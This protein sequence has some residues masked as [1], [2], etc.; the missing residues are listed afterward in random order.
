MPGRTPPYRHSRVQPLGA[1]EDRPYHLEIILIGLR[2]FEL[3]D[4]ALDTPS[5]LLDLLFGGVEGAADPGNDRVFPIEL[6]RHLFDD[7]LQ[8]TQLAPAQPDAL[9]KLCEQRRSEVITP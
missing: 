4:I 7:S 5:H 6:P 9:A 8:R 1:P 2:H 3:A